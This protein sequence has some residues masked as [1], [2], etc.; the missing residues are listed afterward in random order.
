MQLPDQPKSLKN[1]FKQAWL[2]LGTPGY[3]EP[4]VVFLDYLIFLW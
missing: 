2:W 4:T 1:N 3:N